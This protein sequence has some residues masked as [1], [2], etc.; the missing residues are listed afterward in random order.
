MSIWFSFFFFFGKTVVYSQSGFSWSV[1]SSNA[2]RCERSSSYECTGQL[3]RDEFEP[4][5]C[6]HQVFATSF[7]GH[8]HLRLSFEGIQVHESNSKKN[9]C[10]QLDSIDNNMCYECSDVTGSIAIPENWIFLM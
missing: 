10:G 1:K 8:I 6:T 4:D 2:C 7:D 3:T 5:I 9:N